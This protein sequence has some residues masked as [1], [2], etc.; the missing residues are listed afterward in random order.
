[1]E[2]TV[3]GGGGYAVCYAAIAGP[4]RV[5]RNA[6]SSMVGAAQILEFPTHAH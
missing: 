3:T 6:L 4:H 1:M 5:R 2:G